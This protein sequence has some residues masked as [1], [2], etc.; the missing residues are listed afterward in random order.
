VL[1]PCPAQL[2]YELPYE[3]RCPAPLL[4]LRQIAYELIIIAIISLSLSFVS[5]YEILVGGIACGI[6]VGVLLVEY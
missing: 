4:T 6:L 3:N 1:C 2:N 5:Y